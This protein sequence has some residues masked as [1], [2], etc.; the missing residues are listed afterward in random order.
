MYRGTSRCSMHFS[1]RSDFCRSCITARSPV[2]AHCAAMQSCWV[3]NPKRMSY[4]ICASECVHGNLRKI[5]TY[6]RL[7]NDAGGFSQPATEDRHVELRMSCRADFK[8][9]KNDK[10]IH[11]ARL[12]EEV[13]DAAKDYGVGLSSNMMVSSKPVICLL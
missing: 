10:S 9:V 5:E 11:F 6:G 1:V 3:L 4:S 2:A 7:H 13:A 12:G 8:D